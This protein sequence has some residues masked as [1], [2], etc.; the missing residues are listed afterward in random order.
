MKKGS[1]KN[2]VAILCFLT[3]FANPLIAHTKEK[4]KPKI[5]NIVNFIRLL[6]PRDEKITRDVLYQTV[7]KQLE[8]MKKH[9]AAALPAA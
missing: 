5:I 2:R 7:V 8:M 4:P 1:L 9:G 6:E 3:V